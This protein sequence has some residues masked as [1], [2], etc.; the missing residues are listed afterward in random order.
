MTRALSD[1]DR[2]QLVRLPAWA[3]WGR[4]D[5]GRPDPEAV[6]GAIYGMGRADR[7]GDGDEDAAPDDP[8]PQIDHADAAHLDRLITRLADDH[9]YVLVGYYYK[10]KGGYLPRVHAAIR[11]LLDAEYAAER[12]RA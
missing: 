9:K 1:F 4:Q 12:R 5:S 7:D 10:R 6:T 3:R 8:P 11:A 2:M